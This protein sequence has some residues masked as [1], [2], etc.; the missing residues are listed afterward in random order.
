MF[1]PVQL[2]TGSAREIVDGFNAAM[3]TLEERISS[4]EAT[5]E[6]SP[7]Q[8][9]NEPS[10]LSRLEARVQSL[11]AGAVL[12]FRS[13]LASI[14]TESKVEFKHVGMTISEL[15]TAMRHP[16][17]AGEALKTQMEAKASAKAIVDGA[18]F[19]H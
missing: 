9:T 19:G 17:Q 16:I 3:K 7:T 5:I 14:T 13:A 6:D 2:L 10:I 11:E 4:L 8:A 1:N 18:Q 12:E 15:L